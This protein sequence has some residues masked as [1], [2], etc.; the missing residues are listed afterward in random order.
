[1]T[2]TTIYDYLPENSPAY[3]FVSAVYSEL[4]S[5]NNKI[6]PTFIT[7]L[8]AQSNIKYG[9]PTANMRVCTITLPTGHEVIGVAQVLDSNNDIEAIGNQVALTNATNELWKLVGTVAKLFI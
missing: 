2:Q 9:Q 7:S 5:N 8:V 1:M 3:D 4:T 6:P